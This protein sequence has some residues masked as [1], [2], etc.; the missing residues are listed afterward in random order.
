MHLKKRRN[1][2][3]LVK[4]YKPGRRNKIKQARVAFLKAGVSAYTGRKLKKRFNRGIWQIRINAAARE[5]GT[6]YSRLIDALKK[7]NIALDRKVLS[8]IAMDHPAIFQKIID[9][10][11]ARH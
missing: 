4:G 1:L 10:T 5:N 9:A 11:T 7:A 3:K 6:T 2:L 8:Q